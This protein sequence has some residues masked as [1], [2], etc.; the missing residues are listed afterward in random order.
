MSAHP[1]ALRSARA[2]D[3]PNRSL[4]APAPSPAAARVSTLLRAVVTRSSTAPVA[5]FRPGTPTTRSDRASPSTSPTIGTAVWHVAA[6][7]PGGFAT[8]PVSTTAATPAALVGNRRCE[9]M[10]CPLG[11]GTGLFQFTVGPQSCSVR[12]SE[13]PEAEPLRELLG[14]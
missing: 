1:S 9:P 6:A 7:A 13:D 14:F 10:T 12:A 8:S 2:T 3:D 11:P 5:R 4:G